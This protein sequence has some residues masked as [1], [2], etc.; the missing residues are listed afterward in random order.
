[1][2]ARLNSD[3]AAAAPFEIGDDE[4]VVNINA[5]RRAVTLLVASITLT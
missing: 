2:I 4:S 5:L 1:V 3:R